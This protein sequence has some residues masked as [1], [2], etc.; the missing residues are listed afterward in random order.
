MDKVKSILFLTTANLATN[1]RC[2]KEVQSSIRF[3]YKPIIVAFH[4]GGWSVEIEKKINEHIDKLE[5]HYIDST[6]SGGF[7]WLIASIIHKALSY[8]PVISKNSVLLKSILIDKKSFLL[9]QFINKSKIQSQIVIA[10][11]PGSF[12]AAAQFA[13]T[14][15]AKLVFDIEDYH[16]GE[17]KSL[18]HRIWME[19][20]MISIL[21]LANHISCASQMIEERVV[22]LV[23]D[24]IKNKINF[25][26]NN[27]PSSEFLMPKEISGKIKLVWF[28][29]NIDYGR[30]LEIILPVVDRYS[31]E[32]EL[33][34]IGNLRLGFYQNELVNRNYI[35]IANPLTQIELHKKLSGFDIG[36]AIE[37][38]DE[39]E[40]RNI[41]L[42]NKIWA[43]FQSGLFIIATNTKAQSE[44][45][46]LFPFHG[47]LMKYE[48]S[49]IADCLERIFAK[50]EIIR[51]QK[52]KRYIL[53]KDYSWDIEQAKFL[54][55]IN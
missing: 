7:N 48:E 22:D 30:G 42:T 17:Y 20:Y 2:F 24:T 50:I 9:T 25:V 37:D 41:C 51:I 13:K 8:F 29:Q 26:N 10:H 45:I 36:L 6:K 11:N 33:T 27:F 18:K 23:G 1:P 16:P 15:R 38:V 54:N 35:K 14:Y 32:I 12:Y 31:N 53:A 52:N 34:L 39:N 46:E 40:N 5:I 19:N 3:G 4:V 47:E 21:P 28:S 49:N 43:Y 55:V 44:F